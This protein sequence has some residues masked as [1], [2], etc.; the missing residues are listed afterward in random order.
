V[1]IYIYCIQIIF[2]EWRTCSPCAAKHPFWKK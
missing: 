1:L 2:R